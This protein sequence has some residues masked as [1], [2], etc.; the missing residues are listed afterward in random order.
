[1][2]GRLAP[3]RI[4]FAAAGLLANGLRRPVQAMLG[5]TISGLALKITKAADQ[6]KSGHQ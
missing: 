1:M 2:T 3:H 4:D 5:L 6:I